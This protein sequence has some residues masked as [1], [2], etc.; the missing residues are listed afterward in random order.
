[1][2]IFSYFLFSF[3]AFLI[4]SLSL[5]Y[6]ASLIYA[7]LVLLIFNISG[8]YA[9]FRNISYNSSY[10]YIL[11]Y[12]TLTFFFFSL[13]MPI[14]VS[15]T[16]P[17]LSNCSINSYPVTSLLRFSIYIVTFL[18][19]FF[20]DSNILFL[21]SL[22]SFSYLSDYVLFAFLLCFSWYLVLFSVLLDF[23]LLLFFLFFYLIYFFIPP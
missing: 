15:F 8:C 5:Y 6:E 1:V 17:K 14:I 12:P 23:F 18:L 16:Y 20:S 22:N 10:V 9:A 11:I 3:Y 4:L 7:G 21:N 19:I 2:I 13:T